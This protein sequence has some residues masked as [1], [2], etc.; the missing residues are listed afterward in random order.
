M[1]EG[2]GD[3]TIGAIHRLARR[4]DGRALK[5]VAF[6]T[7]E[8]RN[9][10]RLH[11]FLLLASPRDVD[12]EPIRRQYR[13][14]GEASGDPTRARLRSKKMKTLDEIRFSLRTRRSPRHG[15]DR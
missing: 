4:D 3:P 2:S 7:I 14:W 5:G 1:R 15:E 11:A 9:D 8:S 13:A 10:P 12:L 6:D